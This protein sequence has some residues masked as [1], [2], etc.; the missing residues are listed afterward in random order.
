MSFFSSCLQ[1]QISAHSEFLLSD[2]FNSLVCVLFCLFGD[3]KLSY[4]RT[5]RKAWAIYSIALCSPVIVSTMWLAGRP[6]FTW[7]IIPLSIALK[8]NAGRWRKVKSEVR[9][10]VSLRVSRASEDR[11]SMVYILLPVWFFYIAL[12]V[13]MF[14]FIIEI[15]LPSSKVILQSKIPSFKIYQK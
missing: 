6:W 8:I 2:L 9:E 11:C 14:T 15:M 3:E 5:R 1:S 4:L 12:T 10:N 7:V 13:T